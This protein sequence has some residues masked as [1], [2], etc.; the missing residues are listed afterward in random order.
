MKTT[1]IRMDDEMVSRIDAMAEHLNRSRSWLI[2]QAV[3]NFLSHEE[4][5]VKE[6][7]DGLAEAKRGEFATD[8]EIA[9]Q[10]KKWGVNAG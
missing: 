2:N 6:I 8:R 1:T 5:L 3:D 10:F 9:A 7:E 4:W